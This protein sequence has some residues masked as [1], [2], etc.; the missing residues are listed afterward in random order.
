MERYIVAAVGGVIA[1]AALIFLGK[2]LIL[3]LTGA[4]VEAEVIAVTEPK[5]GVYV[6]KL[7]YAVGGKTIESEDKTGYSQPFSRGEVKT[8]VCSKSDPKVFEYE[9]QLRKNML[10]SG[11]LVVMAVLIVLRFLFFVRDGELEEDIKLA[12]TGLPC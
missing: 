1:L 7:R 10:I 4:V 2:L 12:L 8:I 9:A 5:Q 11:I 6:H 3:K